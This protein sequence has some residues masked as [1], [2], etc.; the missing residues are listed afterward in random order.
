MAVLEVLEGFNVG[1]C[2]VVDDDTMVGRSLSNNICL[3]DS[4][5]SRHHARLTRRG[6][7]YFIEDQKSANGTMVRGVLITPGQA[8]EIQDGDEI[9]ICSTR[10]V[11]RTGA[12]P[13]GGAPD[14]AA[15]PA[16][17][18]GA[19]GGL[20]AALGSQ[21]TRPV[22]RAR[23]AGEGMRVEM[24]EEEGPEAP[25]VNMTL[26]AGQS[27]L[28]V[29]DHERQSEKGMQDAL[30]RL[31]AMLQVS[32]ALG[33]ILD[34]DDLMQ[35]IMQLVFDIFPSADRSFI[36]L[37]E[38]GGELKMVAFQTRDASAQGE[39]KVAISNTIVRTVMEDKQSLLSNDA[40]S[41][42]RFQNQMSIVNLSI[43]SMMCAPLTAGE[44]ILGLIQVDSTRGVHSF[45][46]EDMKVLTGIAAQA[47]VAVKNT[48]L[49][50]AIEKETLRRTSLQ[51]YFSPN[52]VEMMM[53][54]DLDTELGGKSYRGTV[55]FSDIIGFTAMS[56]TMTAA[57]VVAKLNRYFNVMQKS[58]YDN[59]GNVDKFGGDA[60]MAFWSVPQHTDGD[61]RRAVL[62][63]VEMQGKLW[64]FNLELQADGIKPIYAGI[65]LNTGDFVAGNVGSEDKIEFTLIGDNVNLASRIE[66]CAGRWQVF[67][68]EE[69]Y[70]A[71]KEEV[72]AVRLP[73][74]LFKG[75]S[76][77]RQP[78]SI[79]VVRRS[80]DDYA[81]AITCILSQRGE[82]VAEGIL[83]AMSGE[84]DQKR[85]QLHCAAKLDG[86][87]PLLLRLAC[88]EYHA[89]LEMTACIEGSSSVLIREEPELSYCRYILS[90]M[91][92]DQALRF[93][94]P[95]SCLETEC[96][97]DDIRRV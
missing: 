91:Q 60:I 37:R 86:D 62:T 27:M 29:E 26:D 13:P 83:T 33:N 5:A 63:G 97:W 30:R 17:A 43:R 32:E 54:G 92:G 74:I 58:I 25:A 15:P 81:L 52:M 96:T 38:G 20:G 35:Q 31:Q 22:P 44:E 75:K 51:R 6:D 78:Y 89:P 87:Q 71:I 16:P 8:V 14:S 55:F 1:E 45:E 48:Q 34:L 28:V 59:G 64:P 82:A 9:R 46:E 11:F 79:R 61:E 53:A 94:T 69:T 10:L 19:G 77:P 88:S 7:T 41:D 50:D 3:P 23:P 18:P 67:V 84:G 70:E 65:G 39:E 57:D 95:G 47:A 80:Q 49:V 21:V 72:C 66:S 56:E 73:S 4:R 2:F 85:L 36:L 90:G 93:L 12:K 24:V 42:D 40:M 68:S 76:K